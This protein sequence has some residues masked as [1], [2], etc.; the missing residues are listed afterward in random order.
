MFDIFLI[1]NNNFDV[2][3]ISINKFLVYKGSNRRVW[4]KVKIQNHSKQDECFLEKINPD[5]CNKI[6]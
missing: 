2:I 4:F 1:L 3:L 6:K 5:R